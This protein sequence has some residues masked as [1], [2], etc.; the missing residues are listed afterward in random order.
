L[1]L[2]SRHPIHHLVHNKQQRNMVG[3]QLELI[4]VN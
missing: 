1:Y 2:N 3:I 4:W